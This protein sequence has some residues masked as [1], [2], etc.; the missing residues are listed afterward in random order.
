MLIVSLQNDHV[1]LGWNPEATTNQVKI[2]WEPRP[3]R[4]L[5]LKVCEAELCEEWAKHYRR[6]D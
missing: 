3:L 6:I 2:R 4:I 1:Q 5:E